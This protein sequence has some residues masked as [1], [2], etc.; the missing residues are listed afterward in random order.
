[1]TNNFIIEE[2]VG[3]SRFLSI[4][5]IWLKIED[6]RV[7]PWPAFSYRVKESV[8]FGFPGFITLEKKN[9]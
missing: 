9:C 3:Q 1:V 4:Q 2:P 7:N 6:D 8:N 5:I